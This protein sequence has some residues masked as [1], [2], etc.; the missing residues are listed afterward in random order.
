RG[1]VWIFAGDPLVHLEQVA[2]AIGDDLLAEAADGVGEVEIDRHLA[3]ADAAALVAHGLGGARG[4]V[5]RDQ[6]AEAGVATLEVVVALA[7]ADLV[8][9]ARVV[10]LLGH[11]HAAVVAQ[12][13]G[14]QGQLG[15]IVAADRDAGRVDLGEAGVGEPGP[16]L[17]GAIAGG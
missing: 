8:G 9:A 17:V 13:L 14:H 6:V 12:R 7:L 5:A 15:L 11:P 4:G 16:A 3:R 10:L 2:V 1:L